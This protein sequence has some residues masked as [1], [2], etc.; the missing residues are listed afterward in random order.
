MNKK[1]LLAL[2]MALV[3]TLTLVPVTAFAEVP[4]NTS[5]DFYVDNDGVYHIA[6]LDGLKA[7]RDSVNSG[8]TYE[9]MTVQLDAN[10]D[11]S[12]DVDSNNQQ[13][14]W[15]PI[16]GF[17]ANY[18]YGTFD[19][20]SN[21]ISNLYISN[22]SLDGAGLFGSISKGE[23]KNL[24]LNNI[25]ISANRYLGSVAGYCYS[26]TIDNCEVSGTISIIGHYMQG[27]IV[28]QSY[29]DISDCH[30]NGTDLTTSS[31]SSTYDKNDLEGDN[32][33]GI[34]GHWSEYSTPNWP[35]MSNCSVSNISIS[36]TR[37]VGGMVG[38]SF[39][40]A[41]Y[42]NCTVDSLNVTTNATSDYAHANS[43]KMGVGGFVGMF[44]NDTTH[45]GS[46]SAVS[47]S[48]IT[49]D[50]TIDDVKSIARMGYVSG[51]LYGR[52]T[53]TAPDSIN[54]NSENGITVGGIN[55]STGVLSCNDVC[56]QAPGVTPASTP[57]AQIGETKYETL[58]A[59]FAAAQD[60]DTI[61]LLAD[62]EL[63]AAVTL[64]AGTITFLLNGHEV[65]DTYE[66]TV[67]EG[68]TLIAD[69]YSNRYIASD[70]YVI[71]AIESPSGTWTYTVT[72]TT[73]PASVTHEGTIT[74]YEDVNTAI[75]AAADGDTV[76]LNE[77]T[78]IS[79]APKSSRGNI[80]L[81]LNGK[82]A[83]NGVS[84][85]GSTNLTITNG[86]VTK[87]NSTS[88]KAVS[89]S[90]GSGT[91]TLDNVTVSSTGY[92][93]HSAPGYNDTTGSIVV[94]G[95]T[96]T[97]TTGAI[98]VEK[99]GGSSR[100]NG[101]NIVIYGGTFNGAIVVNAGTLTIYGGIF[102][103][104]PSTYVAQGYKAVYDDFYETWTVVPEDAVA[105]IGGK[106][107]T[108]LADA[109]N[110][111]GDDEVITMIADVDNAVGISVPSG[112]NFTVDFNNHFY[113]V[114]KPGAGSPGTTTNAFQL[115]KDSDITFQNGT[116][117]VSE[118]NLTPA[119]TGKNIKRIIQNY[120]NLNLYNMTIDA[121]NQYEL[122]N[123]A[124]SFCNG[125][126]V[127]DSTT[128]TGVEGTA[129][130]I[131][132]Y[133]SYPSVSVKV[134]GES[135]IDGDIEI[136]ASDNSA[137]EGLTLELYL[138][139]E[140]HGNI[141]L[142]DSV[143][144]LIGT[145]KVSIS[146]DWAVDADA[147]AGYKWDD[148]T[149]LVKVTNVAKI[150]ST[151]YTTLAAAISDVPKDGTKT[152]ITLLDD[153]NN[154]TVAINGGRNIVLDLDGNTVDADFMYVLNG[155]L[156]VQNG[157]IA[158]SVNV[159]GLNTDGAM[160]STFKLDSDAAISAE[161][162]VILREYP[163]SNAAYNATVTIDGN[164]Y[165]CIWVMGN[166]HEGDSVVNVNG[167]VEADVTVGLALQGYATANVNSGA[168]I[169]PGSNEPGTGIEVRGGTLNVSGGT[170]SGYGSPSSAT[171]NGNGTT[172]E[173][174]GIAI[175]TYNNSDV[176]VNISGGTISGY[177]PLYL[178]NTT[179]N[180]HELNVS[181]S[182]G[183]FRLTDNGTAVVAVNEDSPEDRAVGFI[184][185]GTFSSKPAE[186]YIAETYAAVQPDNQSEWQVGK[187]VTTN[188]TAAS[189][190]E[191]AIEANS[192]TYTVNTS[193]VDSSN[194]NEVLGSLG[195]NQSLT[196]T[197]TTADGDKIYS[198]VN[199][200]DTTNKKPVGAAALSQ[201]KDASAVASVIEAAVS[202][203]SSAASS[204]SAISVVL[205]S[206]AGTE[207]MDSNNSVA[208]VTYEV[209]PEAIVYS[210]DAD[211]K[212]VIGS[213]HITND[214]LK[215]DT[216]FTVTLPVDSSWNGQTINIT[217]TK[218]DGELETIQVVAANDSVTFTVSEFSEFELEPVS[219]DGYG[220]NYV[221][222]SSLILD[223]YINVA[224]YVHL[225]DEVVN[226][227]HA[228]I[229]LTQTSH[230]GTVNSKSFSISDGEVTSD[231]YKF[232]F[233]VAAK[234][235]DVKIQLHLYD[236]ENI[237][238]LTN[239]NS[240]KME[241]GGV[242]YAVTDYLANKANSSNQEL[243]EL[244]EAL[245]AY[246]ES[247]LFY[248]DHRD[249]EGTYVRSGA[250]NPEAL[251]TN[252][253]PTAK[254]VNADSGFEG[255]SIQS[256]SLM[257]VSQTTIRFYF[258]LE[259]G[260]NISD[261]TFR[262]GNT[263]LTPTQ[264]GSTSIYYVEVPPIAAKKL[265]D[266]QTV[267]VTQNSNDSTYTVTYG[268]FN[269]IKANANSTTAGLAD[270]VTAIY[271]YQVKAAAYF[272]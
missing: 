114:N 163:N 80:T 96:Y 67:P 45:S 197:G 131:C 31:I 48:N 71:S 196:V 206:D 87:G 69:N 174:A 81:D 248:F 98:L 149:E 171:A 191:N 262:C 170:I 255:L 250:H 169:K 144:D 115:L 13:I 137:N 68:T 213:Y 204:A 16:G 152:T 215:E 3:M 200:G 5:G 214:Q 158:N 239:T 173:G 54:V 201:L 11:L 186:A 95:G 37:K 212:T 24:K 189:I 256:T 23:I 220:S 199:T 124:I 34:V 132:R 177:S 85:A 90:G 155:A 60:G 205:V 270:L 22:D 234:D 172:S 73:W 211:Q 209:H 36:G 179:G 113:T 237:I 121:T 26:S 56:V 93:I 58:Q 235:M 258:K 245:Y 151:E 41:A 6:N 82:T 203:A 228:T 229:E 43:T 103:H 70:G 50:A 42:S 44:Y 57:V 136:S 269:Y 18:F 168:T 97:G 88:V 100:T 243:R 141:V 207:I 64:P 162:G 105:V 202:N 166:I 264:K 46:M 159:Y 108:S 246:H 15:V 224:F 178:V 160:S 52:D 240:Y 118:D 62:C 86:T 107:Y 55:S 208:K 232:V 156:E 1:K 35:S 61:T 241:D 221:T 154:E 94:N 106:G 219:L 12:T 63:G 128:I 2:L 176:E 75:W 79:L 111:V 146:K 120:A 142:D 253:E 53:I 112:K 238:P 165:G 227:P 66:I 10:I 77:N 89:I 226:N 267:T 33:G 272:G 192:V 116:I 20:K 109:I 92:A 217:H 140:L 187:V 139:T 266:Q 148:D 125:D 268:P 218:E 19:G 249:G 251:P 102:D 242:Q 14:S 265:N 271:W 164:V 183:T 38:L 153:V 161:Y 134:Q 65:T 210:V 21:C 76:T 263:E 194:E 51:G 261:Y 259:S 185:G 72:E 230:M 195:S 184:T 193:V 231:G 133:A 157:A 9:G 126:S 40:R 84:G 225:E 59:A 127:I 254:S 110:D 198:S 135:V 78:E 7:F 190:T 188:A 99:A 129:F 236:G 216:S 25:S 252:F 147:P 8:D 74:N 130:A 123:T 101:G 181:V 233:P 145:E 27:G 119:T 143:N 30:V 247:S 244:V 39:E 122:K 180:D 222:K 91:V 29:A 28:G 4:T 138:N 175:S 49:L 260:H 257:L 32:V 150:G 167:F 83:S 47:I 17:K 104:D 223:G 117:R 182:G